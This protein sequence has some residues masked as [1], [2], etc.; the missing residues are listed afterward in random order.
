MFRPSSSDPPRQDP[1]SPH[2]TPHDEKVVAQRLLTLESKE[3]GGYIRSKLNSSLFVNLGMY[4]MALVPILV[5]AGIWHFKVSHVWDNYVSPYQRPPSSEE[6]ERW[7]EEEKRVAKER[8]RAAL[9]GGASSACVLRNT[10]GVWGFG[11]KSP[12]SV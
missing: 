9:T 4:S 2:P 6:L 11:Q 10:P 1:T 5:I 7:E 8:K 3:A 12:P